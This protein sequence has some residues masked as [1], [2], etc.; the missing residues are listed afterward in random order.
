MLFVLLAL[1]TLAFF[2]ICIGYIAVSD[3]RKK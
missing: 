1:V 3:R 2:L